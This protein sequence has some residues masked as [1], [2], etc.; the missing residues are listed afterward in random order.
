ML[1]AADVA[2]SPLHLYHLY[3]DRPISLKPLQPMP[4]GGSL[5]Q[6]IHLHLGVMLLALSKLQLD[7]RV[8]TFYIQFDFSLV[9][10]QVSLPA[11]HYTSRTP[12]TWASCCLPSPSY[13]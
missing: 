12:S 9:L 5:H 11:P 2:G 8:S 13:S 3:Q 1:Y 10:M 6:Q 7:L 4:A